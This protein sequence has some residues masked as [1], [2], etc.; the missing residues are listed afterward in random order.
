MGKLSDS[1][2]RLILEI[3]AILIVCVFLFSSIATSLEHSKT[4]IVSKPKYKDQVNMLSQHNGISSM[5]YSRS[6][7]S[8]ST[9]LEKSKPSRVNIRKTDFQVYPFDSTEPAPMGI[10]DYGIGPNGSP[11]KYNTTSFLGIVGINSLS[12]YN[13]SLNYPYFGGPYGMSFQ[14]NLNLVFNNSNSEYVYWVQDMAFLD[15]SSHEIVFLDNIWNLSSPLAEMHSSTVLGNGTLANSS[16]TYYYFDRASLFLPGNYAFLQYPTNIEFKIV[17]T[18]SNNQPEVIFLYNDGYGWITYD[19]VLFKFVDDLTTDYGFVVNGST[20]NPYFTFYDAELILGGPGNGSQTRDVSSNLRLQLEYW[21]GHNFQQ[22]VNAYNFGSDTA[23]GISNVSTALGYY[24]ENGSLS[25]ILYNSPGELGVLYNSSEI[26]VL[27]VNSQLNSGTLYVNNT[28][29][30][31]VNGQVNITLMPNYDGYY[32]LYLYNSQNQLVWQ[33]RVSLAPG[34]FLNLS[35]SPA[36]YLVTFDESGLP[37]GQEWYVNISGPSG[38]IG[39]QYS[40]SNLLTFAEPLPDGTYSYYLETLNGNYKASPSSGTFIISGSNTTVQITFTLSK[41][42]ITFVE[43][44]LPSGTVWSITLVNDNNSGPIKNTVSSQTNEI[45]FTAPPGVYYYLVNFVNGYVPTVSINFGNVT[46]NTTQ[47]VEFVKATNQYVQGSG[48]PGFILYDKLNKLVYLSNFN[49]SSVS[50]IDGYQIVGDISVTQYPEELVLDPNNGM[51]YVLM[52]SGGI[53]VIN[54]VGNYATLILKNYYFSNLL[55]DPDNGY[56][57]ASGYNNLTEINP[58]TEQIIQVISVDVPIEEMTLDTQNQEIYVISGQNISV[59]N[60]LNGNLEGVINLNYFPNWIVYDTANNEIYV[61]GSSFNSNAIGMNV[62]SSNGYLSIISGYSVIKEIFTKFYP[63]GLSIDPL[64]GNV[65]V[66]NLISDDIEVIDSLNN[67]VIGNIAAYTPLLSTFDTSNGLLYITSA[68]VNYVFI[69]PIQE[70]YTVTFKS[71]GLPLGIAWYVN[72]SNVGLFE[73]TNNSISISISEG[74]Y[75]Y[76]IFT[77]DKE[78]TPINYKGLLTVDGKNVTIYVDFAL[79]TYSVLF[80]QTG[81]PTGSTWYVNITESN[82][83]VYYSGA[84]S[85]S[86]YSFSLTNGSYTYTIAISNKTYEP[87]PFSGSFE[88]VGSSPSAIDVAFKELTYSVTFTESG[89]PS[90]TMWYVNLTESNGTIYRSGGTTGT[91]L[92]FSSLV[93][94][95]YSYTIATSDHTYKPSAS[96]GSLTVNGKNQ[97]ISVAFTEVKY[98]V[99]FTE[100]GLQSGT[101]W[102]VNIT[103]SNGP[104]YYSGAISGSSYTFS[105]TNGTYSYTVGSVSGYSVSPSFGNV[106]VSGNNVPVA[107]TFTPVKTIVS[108]YTITFTEAG[109]PSGTSW[110]V[111]LNGISESSTTNTITFTMPNG[112]Y[113]YAIGSISGYTVSTSS[114]SMTVNGSNMSQTITFT[115]VKITV[116]KYTVT[117]TESGLPSGTEWYVNITASNGTTYDSGPITNSSYSFQLSNGTYSYTISSISGYNT[118]QRSGSIGVSGRNTSQSATF[119]KVS[120][121]P[122]PKKPT[123]PTTP[124]TDLYIIIGAVAAIAVIGAIVAIMMRKR[125]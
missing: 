13:S 94:G 119:S 57:Y 7:A 108:N 69:V 117:F 31:F 52:G 67:T 66:S 39:T 113:S 47:Y 1:K 68:E 59:I 4:D 90:G 35:T 79:V 89:L 63:L 96:S 51:V 74:N 34:E 120:S 29:Y 12:T 20:Y 105:L 37:V 49:S 97:T 6:T 91:S 81:L 25:E 95:T 83:T 76:V 15:T 46:S 110:S 50:V 78:Y 70:N 45:I 103:E 111:T 43:T 9:N 56:L 2:K 88:V 11:Y 77:S 80:A 112:T 42:Q 23:E 27:Q 55:F 84:I 125:K 92:T 72:I 62:Y 123:S 61:S 115:P 86:Y 60:L 28:P 24:P 48:G 99:T 98:T 18:T 109:L 65:F 38:Y 26:A 104:V 106:N 101:I 33:K 41:V 114:G 32:I 30:N 21:N 100:S 17:S 64:N 75:N 121:T 5:D 36:T 19:N 40:S 71:S 87:S 3:F 122:P 73:T 82:G 93:N 14:L 85:G 118:T 22:V 54:T 44:G 16:G 8:F 58:L 10:A 53:G 124:N 116:M 102:Y 107:I